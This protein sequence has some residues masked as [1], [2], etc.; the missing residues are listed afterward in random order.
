MVA[1]DRRADALRRAQGEG[2]IKAFMR[3]DGEGPPQRRRGGRRDRQALEA[4]RADRH[5]GRGDRRDRRPLRPPRAQRRARGREGRRGGA[6][7]SRSSR[8]RCGGS[9]RT[10]WSR[11][12]RSRTSSPRSARRP[13]PRRR[14]PTATSARRPRARSSAANAMQ[15]VSGI[16]AGIQETSDAARV[17]HLATQ[18]QRT[19]TEQVVQ[20]MSEIEEVTRQAQAG[21]EAGHRRRR[22]AHEARRAARRAREAL[23]GRVARPGH[24]RP[25]PSDGRLRR[26]PQEAPPEVPR[27]HRG[28]GGEDLGRAARA[29]A[30]AP[31][32]PRLL[33]ELARELHTLKGEARMMGF[34]GISTRRARGGGPPEGAAAGEPGERLD[35]LL[36]ACDEIV[37]LLDA[38]VDGGEAAARLAA[39]L[40]ALDRG[41][42]RRAA[43]ARAR[44]AAPR[45]HAPVAA[46]ESPTHHGRAR[47]REGPTPKARSSSAA[48]ARRLDPRRRRP[49]RRDRRARRRR[50]GRGRALNPSLAGPER[51]VRA[52]GAALR[53][54]DRARRAAPRHAHGAA[55]RADGGR[56]PPAALR[57]LPLRPRADARPPPRPRRSSGC[58]PSGSAT[59][60]SSR[61]PACSRLPPRRARH[62]ARAGEGGRVRRPGRRDRRR[63]GDPALAQ[64][65]ARP[66]RP[67]LRGPRHR[68]AGRAD[69]TRASPALGK[70][71]IS[72]RVDGDLLAIT[73][74]DDGRGIRPQKVRA[75]GAA[76]GDHRR[77]AG[78][79]PVR[80]RG[81]RPHLH[82]GLLDPRAGGRDE[83][84][85]RRARRGPQA[86]HL[87]R[88]L[89]RRSSR[90][91]AR[92]RG[93][94]CACRSRSR[95]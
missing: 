47:D 45:R 51:A 53:Q 34:V 36:K 38:P 42:R 32:R 78:G 8:P 22:R 54:G 93:S 52:L 19:A 26:D 33:D 44:P 37:P 11:R 81:A 23:Q 90:S 3:L 76:Q 49:A 62:G 17:I 92:A 2:A 65:P 16:L 50:A 73:V 46:D 87:A 70:I 74:E 79:E 59:P 6:R 84:A 72:A 14:P 4:R 91:R 95:S 21:L 94:R 10:S 29:R 41:H 31:A 12:R 43:T 18:Q 28:P 20:S 56:R 30:R 68:D 13:T 63:Q 25:R 89:R 48:K 61:S 1:R 15:S 64:R 35:A 40:R 9:P 67:Q 85:R 5:G 71:V 75:V 83:R 58:S 88:R 66:P 86:R 69:R 57:H 77:A 80:A 27:D 7:A 24:G 39:S 82:A 60:A 55:R